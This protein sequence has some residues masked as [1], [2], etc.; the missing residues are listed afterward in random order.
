VLFGADDGLLRCLDLADGGELWSYDTS[1]DVLIFGNEDGRIQSSPAVAG[2]RVVFGASNGNVYC[3]GGEPSAGPTVVQTRFGSPLMRG[4][5]AVLGWML[6]FLGDLAGSTGLAVVLVAL[7][8]KSLL[9]PLDWKGA[10]QAVRARSL[11]P[12]LDRMRREHVDYR[13][14]RY[15]V[16]RLFASR[17]VRPLVTLGCVLVQVPVFVLVFTVLFGSPALAGARFLWM[18]DMSLPDRMAGMPALPLLGSDLNLLPAVL[19]VSVWAFFQALRDPG[20]NAGPLRHALWLAASLGLGLITYRWP[21]G[22][23]IFT[24]TLLWAG[25]ASQKLLLRLAAR[26]L[27]RPPAPA[28]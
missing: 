22:L 12:E 7:A 14:H 21:A 6:R 19:A 3:L 18:A 27:P 10:V 4:A 15:E 28:G 25:V 17:G 23:L 13:V 8:L 1:G 9:L 24:V 16:R 11:G 20:V 2:G 26:G 5:D